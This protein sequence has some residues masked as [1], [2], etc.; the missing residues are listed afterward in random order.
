MANATN[1]PAAWGKD[2][3][4]FDAEGSDV[5]NKKELVGVPFLVGNVKFNKG[6]FGPFVSV[7]AVDTSNA[8]FV[9]NDGSTGVYRQIVGKL[10]KAG[11][12]DEGITKPD[13]QEYDVRW[14]CPKGLR[15]SE[16]EG[17]NGKPSMTYYIA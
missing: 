15:V 13:M 5:R 4:A 6:N 16:Y 17:P 3:E 10:H 2:A 8:E 9:F 14:V 1:L 12:L 7:K 11:L